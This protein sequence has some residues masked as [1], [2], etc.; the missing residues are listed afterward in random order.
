MI[1]MIEMIEKEMS[2]REMSEKS[3]RRVVLRS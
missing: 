1:E 3:S 2:K